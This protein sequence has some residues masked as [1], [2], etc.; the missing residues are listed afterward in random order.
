MGRRGIQS[1]G[2]DYFSCFCPDLSYLRIIKRPDFISIINIYFTNIKKDEEN[3][4]YRYE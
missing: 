4:S 3:F 1:H 2:R